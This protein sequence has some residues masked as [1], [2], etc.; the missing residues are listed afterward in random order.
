VVSETNR[1][2]DRIGTKSL[3]LWCVGLLLI[4]AA[5]VVCVAWLR[6]DSQDNAA[7]NTI[8]KRL[9]AI[10][11]AGQPLNMQDLARLYPDPPSSQDAALLLKPGLALLV[12]PEDST[13][14][15]PFFGGDFP[16]ENVPFQKSATDEI[17]AAVD[18]NQAAFDSVP[19]EKLQGTWIGCGFQNGFTNLTDVPISKIDSL[20]KIL[21]LNAV[22]EAEVQHPKEAAQSFER[23]FEIEQTLRND[24]ILHGLARQAIEK[25][26]CSSLNR[27]LDRTM[28]A[29]SDLQ[30]LSGS[31]TRTNFGA[32]RELLINERAFG[33]SSAEYIRSIAVASG[34]THGFSLVRRFLKSYQAKLIYRDQDLLDYLDKA[35]AGFP[36]LDLPL[37]NAIPMLFTSEQHSKKIEDARVQNRGSK[38]LS[39]FKQHRISLLSITTPPD[40]YPLFMSEAKTVAYIR[41]TRAALA[42]ERWRLSHDGRLPESLSVLQPDFLPS[43]PVDPFDEKPLRF[44]KLDRGY[45]V[46]SVGSDF[47]DNGGKRGD[48]FG[49]ESEG[50]DIVFSVTR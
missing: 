46:Y 25:W 3:A 13:T 44:R 22:L 32:T 16:T 34:Q 37:S 39:P 4:G 10:R 43:V 20:I 9:D 17:R 19:W 15:I 31:L 42:V 40:A 38:Y 6:V 48:L 30:L 33:L 26:V 14:N 8:Q 7:R 27:V 24:T 5:T 49:N 1:V 35:K 28:L 12:V 2:R 11:L 47:K 36:A 45:V 21:C 29:D 23:A 50:Y 18:K 41:I